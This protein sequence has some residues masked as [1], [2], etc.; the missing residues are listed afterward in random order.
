[1]QFKEGRKFYKVYL[2]NGI[3]KQDEASTDDIVVR[4][5]E[6]RANGYS[7]FQYTEYDNGEPKT[8][9]WCDRDKF[10]NVIAT[11]YGKSMMMEELD[12]RLAI[13]KFAEHSRKQLAS[14]E[15]KAA[16]ERKWMDIL[17]KISQG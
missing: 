15:E 10:G 11:R 17:G 2:F 4:I 3:M 5:C 14:Y 6:V 7:R 9:L 16:R 1:M 12:I 8:T 13:E